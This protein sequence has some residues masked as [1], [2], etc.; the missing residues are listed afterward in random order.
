VRDAF[1]IDADDWKG[2]V[3]GQFRALALQT[4]NGLANEQS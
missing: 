4:I 1:F 3:L 2:M